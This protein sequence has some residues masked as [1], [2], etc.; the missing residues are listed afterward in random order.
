[1]RSP[2]PV[3][4]SGMRYVD[5]VGGLYNRDAVSGGFGV[6][7]A[8]LSEKLCVRRAQCIPIVRVIYIMMMAMSAVTGM[9]LPAASA[10]APL[11]FQRET[12]RSPYSKD[13]Y[14]VRFVNLDSG[15][16]AGYGANASGFGVRPALLSEKLCVRRHLVTQIDCVMFIF[17][18]KFMTIMLF[19]AASACAPLSFRRNYAFAVLRSFV[20]CPLCPHQRPCH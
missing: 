2:Y 14:H 15:A 7:P 6:R 16:G 18:V 8:L 11:S 13:S 10:C 12:M 3:G 5:L 19:L 4:S 1:M 9:R 20:C 17:R